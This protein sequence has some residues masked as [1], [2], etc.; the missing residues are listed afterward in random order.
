MDSKIVVEYFISFVID[1]DSY[2][3]MEG[4]MIIIIVRFVMLMGASS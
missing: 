2:S 1:I 4:I 3:L